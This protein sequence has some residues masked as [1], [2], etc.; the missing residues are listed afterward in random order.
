MGY[1]WGLS[2]TQSF[3]ETQIH[4]INVGNG[5]LLWTKE[6]KRFWEWER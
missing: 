6:N 4:G 3:H 1:Q 2:G 5:R